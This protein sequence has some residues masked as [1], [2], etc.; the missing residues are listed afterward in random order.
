LFGRLRNRLGLKAA[1]RLREDLEE[2]LDGETTSAQG[3]FSLEERTMLRSILDLKE[4][5]VADLMIPRA[6]ISAVQQDI[7]L[8]ELLEAFE[9][10]G[11]TRLIVFD[12]TLDDPVGMVHIKDLLAY[13]HAAARKSRKKEADDETPLSLAALD[14]G[15]LLSASKLIRPVLFAPPSMPVLDLL[16]KMQASHI[17]IT[18]VIDE[19]GGTEGL[20]ALKDILESIVGEIDDEHDSG[21]DN[22]I[23]A[24]PDGRF[25]ADARAT[26]EDLQERLGETFHIDEDMGEDVDTL[27]GLLTSLA[28]HVPVRGEVV[29]GPG[30]FEFE[31]LDADPRRIKRVR[32]SKAEPLP[33]PVT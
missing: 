29:S 10:S 9:A 14:L 32:I 15:I 1:A 7:S 30:G 31:V 12:D 27:G 24:L 26:L 11:K 13:F 16:Q 19:Y 20:L 23:V 5:R 33:D 4:S 18:L 28:G 2:V 6:D 21:E 3:S 17:H 22:H 25:M 8:S